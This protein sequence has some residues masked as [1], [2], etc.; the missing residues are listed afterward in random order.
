MSQR[1]YKIDFI[2]N[3]MLSETIKTENFITGHY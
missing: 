2:Q 1:L 3:N